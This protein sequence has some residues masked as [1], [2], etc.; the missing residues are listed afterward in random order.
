MSSVRFLFLCGGPGGRRV[1][2][3]P[4]LGKLSSFV[5]LT[6]DTTWIEQRHENMVPHSNPIF[7]RDNCTNLGIQGSFLLLGF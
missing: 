3:G 4:T 1:F 2:G 5:T 6:V 7:D